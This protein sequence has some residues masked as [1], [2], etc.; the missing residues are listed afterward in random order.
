MLGINRLKKK[1]ILN[2]IFSIIKDVSVEKTPN[3][4]KISAKY[5]IFLLSMKKLKTNRPKNIVSNVKGGL[6][7]IFI[8]KEYI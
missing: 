7:F 8:R 4:D 1:D 3:P 2:H 5:K 6:D